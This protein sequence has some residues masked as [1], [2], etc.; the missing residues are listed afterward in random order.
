MMKKML[1]VSFLSLM[2]VVAHAQ[3][4]STVAVYVTGH[5]DKAERNIV[6][7][8]AVARLSKSK[9]YVAV[10]RTGTFMAAL[11]KEQDYQLSGEVAD[12]DIAEL[13][14]RYGARYV[15][16]FEVSKTRDRAMFISARMIDV[17]TGAIVRTAD[18]NRDIRSTDDVVALTN[19]VAYRL[20]S[21]K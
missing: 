9:E 10:E 18:A 2:A 13:G 17:E 6:A 8:K 16:V 12:E 20:I 7:S 11:A 4:K 14:K 19:S 5:A 3:Y 15:A 21:K 1:L